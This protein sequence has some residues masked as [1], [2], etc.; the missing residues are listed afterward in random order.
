LE[1]TGFQKCVCVYA[2]CSARCYR[3][4]FVMSVDFVVLQ[5]APFTCMDTLYIYIYIHTYIHIQYIYNR[6]LYTHTN[7]CT[8]VHPLWEPL[9][10]LC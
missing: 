8:Y 4:H 5:K 9:Q 1:K 10:P 6:T 2:E 7:V 3:A